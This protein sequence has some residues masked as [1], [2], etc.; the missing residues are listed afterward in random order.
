MT[1]QK[2]RNPPIDEEIAETH[3]VKD[4]GRE[5][6]NKSERKMTEQKQKNPP[7]DEEIAETQERSR[8]RS[9]QQ[10]GKKNDEAEAKE[11]RD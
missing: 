5:V 11:T 3:A 7:I 1:E 10:I 9:H 2:Q 6:I 4:Q 8:K